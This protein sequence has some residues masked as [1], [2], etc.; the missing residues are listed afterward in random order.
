MRRGLI[1]TAG[2]ATGRF[3]VPNAEIALGRRGR[4]LDGLLRGHQHAVFRAFVRA[5]SLSAWLVVSGKRE[6]RVAREKAD[7]ATRE[8]EAAFRRY[9]D[10][11]DWVDPN[12]SASVENYPSSA[13][14]SSATVPRPRQHTTVRGRCAGG[15]GLGVA[16]WVSRSTAIRG[17]VMGSRRFWTPARS[18]RG[19]SDGLAYAQPMA[20][21]RITVDP[22]RMGGLACIRDTQVTVAAVLG[23]LAAGRTPEQILSDYPYLEAEDI[24]AALEFAALAVQERELPLARP[25]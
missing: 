16:V 3:T 21:E 14:E 1:G 15:A 13:R 25:A 9:L 2:G 7:H 11:D 4:V 12:L 6:L 24:P 19:L 5:T 17:S 22:R 8:L 23:Q 20:F 18:I 10:N